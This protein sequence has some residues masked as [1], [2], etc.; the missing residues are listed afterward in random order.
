MMVI[1]VSYIDCSHF[2]ST[3]LKIDL[4]LR[5]V[6]FYTLMPPLAS[7]MMAPGLPEIADKYGIK[8]AS[9][10]AL[11]LSVFLISF[12]IGV[13]AVHGLYK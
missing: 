5:Q 2:R 9:I 8:D 10:T 4:P 7:S 6:S 12:A 1:V 11:T 13:S 3:S